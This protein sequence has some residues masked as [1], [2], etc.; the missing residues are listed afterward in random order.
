MNPPPL[1]RFRAPQANGELLVDPPLDRVPEWIERNRV[2]LDTNTVFLGETPLDQFRAEARGELREELGLPDS[3]GP[4]LL[5]GH[6]P[7][8]CHPGVWLK[9]FALAGLAERIQGTAV[10]LVVDTDELKTHSLH[11]P[12]V[13][14]D[15]HHVRLESVP[16]DTG[17]V[18][19]PYAYRFVEDHEL[20]RSL[21][22]RL[23]SRVSAWPFE[24]MLAAAWTKITDGTGTIGERF[25]AARS[26]YEV[27]W[28]C[29]VPTLP[30]S[31]LCKMQS[32]RRFAGSILADLPRFAEAYNGAIREYRRHAKLRSR[33]HPVPELAPGEAPFWT[34]TGTQRR[35]A[36]AQSDPASLVPRALTL[37]LFAR[38]ALGDWFI[39]GIGGG[40]YDEVTDSIIRD[41]YEIEPPMFQVATGTFRLPF[42][43]FPHSSR[44][45]TQLRHRLRD[46]QW[47]PQR[48]LD[49]SR[50]PESIARRTE[51]QSI[52]PDTKAL[53]KERAREIRTLNESLR[54]LVSEVREQLEIGLQIA[55]SE[56][57][58][59]RVLQS[60]EFPWLLFPEETLAPFLKSVQDAARSGESS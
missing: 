26:H 33:T 30:I 29:H 53:R 36:T 7:E 39:H 10:N 44:D 21:P 56:S 43:A 23:A 12:H 32:F 50:A 34:I 57:A 24:P 5:T 1:R 3:G 41:Y 14:P 58:A 31:R 20:F 52:H 8:L 28:G 47:N 40:K 18:D 55:E 17:P 27:T 45:V 35:P 2:K 25:V 49:A 15:P 4:L 6:Q 42:P 13:D 37:T 51:L 22:E 48:S 11:V 46:L 16:F 60:R 38:L 9:T 19:V 54:P 59:N